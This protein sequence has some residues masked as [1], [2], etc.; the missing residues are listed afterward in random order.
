MDDAEREAMSVAEVA[1]ALGISEQLVRL[2][3]KRELLRATRFGKRV[4][5][6]RAELN[7]YLSEREKR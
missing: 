3:I 4:L 7:R 6:R 5:I 1:R 2:E